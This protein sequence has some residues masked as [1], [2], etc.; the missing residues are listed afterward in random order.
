VFIVSGEVTEYHGVNY[1]LVQKLLIRP[2]MG[3]LR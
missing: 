3:N 1:L 2:S